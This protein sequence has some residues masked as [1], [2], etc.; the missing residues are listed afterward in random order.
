M[1]WRRKEERQSNKMK[2]IKFGRKSKRNT[3]KEMKKKW[4]KDNQKKRNIKGDRQKKRERE[5]AEGKEFFFL[6]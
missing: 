5:G 6:I 1:R 3:E 2:R 4:E